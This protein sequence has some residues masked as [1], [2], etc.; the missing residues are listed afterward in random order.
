MVSTSTGG[1]HVGQ[2]RREKRYDFSHQSLEAS[3]VGTLKK[4]GVNGEKW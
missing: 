2:L 3:S 1:E 4:G